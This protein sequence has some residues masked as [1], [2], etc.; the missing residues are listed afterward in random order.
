MRSFF[1]PKILTCFVAAVVVIVVVAVVVVVDVVAAV[2]VVVAVALKHF[3]PKLLRL[4]NGL[5]SNFRE[6]MDL[7]F[8]YLHRLK[9]ISLSLS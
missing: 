1:S 4:K 3:L 2:T 6:L 9:A 8:E 7:N 5:E